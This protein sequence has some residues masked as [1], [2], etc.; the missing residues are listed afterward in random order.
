MWTY[1]I[2]IGQEQLN[3]KEKETAAHAAILNKARDII[4]EKFPQLKV[5]TFLMGLDGVVE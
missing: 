5:Y 1:K 4:K 3:T 2:L